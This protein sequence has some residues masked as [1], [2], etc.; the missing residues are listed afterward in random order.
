MK[1]LLQRFDTGEL[2][3][4]EVPVPAA[5]GVQVLVDVRASLISAG[6]ERALVEFSRSNLLEKARRQPDKVKQVLDKIRTDGIAPTLEAV[7]SKLQ[8]PITLGYCSAGT[9]VEL[10]S[11]ARGFA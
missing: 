6:T 7:R 9:V 11:G 2:R 4:A 10:G 1:Q 8:D 5:T 3:I